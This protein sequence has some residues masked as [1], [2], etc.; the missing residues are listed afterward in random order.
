MRPT[1]EYASTVWDPHN[2]NRSQA[3]LLESVQNKAARF[4]M[5]DWSWSSN[6]TGIKSTC[7][8][9]PLQERRAGACVVIFHKIQHSLVA[10]PMTLFQNTPSTIITRGAP[11][12]F[13]APFCRTQA[14]KNT[15]IPNAPVL[16]NSLPP[17]VATV[18]DPDSFRRSL[19]AVR[20]SA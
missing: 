19:P 7:Q 20:L 14:Y 2:G 15:F 6:V 13:V 1:L 3:N 16:W 18:T 4:V 11:S 17:G 5:S 12:K 10:I 8:W 9:E